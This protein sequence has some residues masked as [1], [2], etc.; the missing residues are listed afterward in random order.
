MGHWIPINETKIRS[1]FEKHFSQP[2]YEFALQRYPE[3][4]AWPGSYRCY[5]EQCAW[6]GWIDAHRHLLTP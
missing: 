3:D 4:S 5:S 1:D 6:E 2:P